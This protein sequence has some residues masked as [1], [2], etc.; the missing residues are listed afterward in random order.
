MND[1]QKSLISP[2]SSVFDALQTVNATQAKI[3]LV[4]DDDRRILGTVTDG[5]IRRGILRQVPLDAAVTLVMN[6]S[7]HVC[8]ED[9]PTTRI[10]A[11]MRRNWLSQ[12]PIV[13]RERRVVGLQ[14]LS[15]LVHTTGCENWVLLMAGGEGRRLRPLT[16]TV[17]KPMLRVGPKPILENIL[18]R[19]IDAGFF[20]F[21]V[22]V[23][24]L[25]DQIIDHFGD[26]SRWGAVIR[27]LHEDSPLG[28]AGPLSLLPDP[29]P[30]PVLVANGDILTNI[31]YRRVLDFHLES[32]AAATMCV[33]EHVME[34]PYGVVD[35][36]DNAIVGIEEKP[37]LRSLVNAGIYVLNG[38]VVRQVPP[39]Q[40]YLMTQLFEGLIAS[41]QRCAAFPISEYWLDVGRHDDLRRASDDFDGVFS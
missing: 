27:Y 16:H 20:N 1:W 14:L 2:G 12:V 17:P 38:D 4:V 26:G 37:A 6:A 11:F 23:N 33:R 5:D 31:D 39:G 24:Y 22:S 40:P 8:C 34:V 7:P 35:V 13:D 10:V 15:G 29:I 41:N 9:E 19:F 18:E 3:A 21:F 32:R 28:T 36:V 25:K 30:G